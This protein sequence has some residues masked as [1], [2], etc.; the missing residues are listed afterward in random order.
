MTLTFLTGREDARSTGRASPH[1]RRG[2]AGTLLVVLVLHWTEQVKVQRRNESRQTWLQD[3]C[4]LGDAK[5][6][7]SDEG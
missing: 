2:G 3:D 6:L 4:G 7:G 1:G 5:F